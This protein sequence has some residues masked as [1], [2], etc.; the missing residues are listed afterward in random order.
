[1]RLKEKILEN[2]TFKSHLLE[3]IVKEAI[4]FFELTPVHK[5]PPEV[6]MPGLGVYGI[7]YTGKLRHYRHM[8]RLNAKECVVPI[9]VGKA[10]PAGWRKGRASSGASGKSVIGRLHEHS[11]SIQA[12]STL[13]IHDFRSRFMIL[14]GIEADLIAAV[15]AQLIRKYQPMWNTL[16]DGFGNHTPGEGRFDQA[17]SEWDVLHPGRVWAAKCRGQPPKLEDILAKIQEHK[18]RLSESG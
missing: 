11:G 1:M 14:G 17:R 7:Y 5:M 13:E 18:R 2:Q 6:S 10:V 8:G 16:V 3:G 9:Y 15:E 4:A 12:S